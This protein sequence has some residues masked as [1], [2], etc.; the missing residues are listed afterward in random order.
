M[1]PN[2]ISQVRHKKH[3][4]LGDTTSK[5]YLKQIFRER[6]GTQSVQVARYVCCNSENKV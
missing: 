6:M 1:V 3:H 2:M 4:N 5:A